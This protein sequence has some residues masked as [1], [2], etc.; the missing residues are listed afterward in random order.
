M[1]HRTAASLAL[2]VAAGAGCW[3]AQSPYARRSNFDRDP[4]VMAH[5]TH[6]KDHDYAQSESE[7][8][9]PDDV[10]PVQAASLSASKKPALGATP[11]PERGHA[12]DYGWLRG[13]A[14]SDGAGGW[15]LRYGSVGDD[16]FGGSMPL[17]PSPRL[18]MLREGDQ[19]YV[20]GRIATAAALPLYQVETLVLAK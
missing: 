9:L 11:R 3:K 19:V 16:R 13:Q 15:R 17:A 6:P 1:R 18:A 8:A 2:A 20:T 4:L 14:A 10:P 7:R 5:L 12:A